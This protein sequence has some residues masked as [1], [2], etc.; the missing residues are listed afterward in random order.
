MR[1]P[2]WTPIFSRTVNVANALPGSNAYE[3]IFP[4]VE[5]T[6][7][8]NRIV[9]LYNGSTTISSEPGW[10]FFTPAVRIEDIRIDRDLWDEEKIYPSNPNV[11]TIVDVTGS[12]YNAN[13][14]DVHRYGD[15]DIFHLNVIGNEFSLYADT[16][17]GWSNA[18]I[19]LEPGDNI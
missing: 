2:I 3:V 13:S 10:V 8:L 12:V 6:E 4:E 18:D 11:S 5:L 19:I 17:G 9:V 7:G 14:I 1:L 16:V 15:E